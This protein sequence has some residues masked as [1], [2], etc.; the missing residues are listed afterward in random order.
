[1]KLIYCLECGDVV[2][3]RTA[4]RS[5]LCGQS[6]GY[7]TTWI[8]AVVTGPCTPLGFDN[9]SFTKALKKPNGKAPLGMEFTAFVIPDNCPTLEHR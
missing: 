5:C 6:S 1:M 9:R 2:A 4:R 8:D 3:L 7:Y